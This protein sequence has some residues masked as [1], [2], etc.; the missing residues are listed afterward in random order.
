MGMIVKTSAEPVWPLFDLRLT[1]KNIHLRPVR[2]SDLS[3]LAQI[4]PDDFEHNPNS[5]YWPGLDL[6]ANRR[7]L[8]FQGYWRNLGAW[9]VE[10]W[11]LTFCTIYEGLIVGMQSLEAEQFTELRTV[12]SGSWLAPSVRGIGIGTSMRT[13]ILGLAFDHLGAQEAITSARLDNAASLG[14]SRRIGYRDN[15]VSTSQSPSGPCQ[16]RHMRLT[17]A[18]WQESALGDSVS[19]AGL[20]GCAAYFGLER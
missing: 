12:D 9:S 19:V 6:A 13:A 15:G 14:V 18:Q 11:D 10:S 5:N 7:R 3:E 8:M 1:C 17:R 2:E 20:S 4:L 16:L